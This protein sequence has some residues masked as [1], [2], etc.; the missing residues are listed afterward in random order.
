MLAFDSTPV[1][2]YEIHAGISR[3]AAL[4]VPALFLES[5]A[6]G[7]ALPEGAISSDGQIFA[8][9]LHGLFESST[10]TDAL[11]RWAGLSNPATPDYHAHRE[12]EIDRLTDALEQHLDLPMLRQLFELEKILDGAN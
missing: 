11:L 3:G 7:Q 5:G 1:T 4:A 9:Y 8:T 12:A 6:D 10:A 2:G